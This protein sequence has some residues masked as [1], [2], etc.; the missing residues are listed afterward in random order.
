[1]ILQ[2]HVC[3]GRTLVSVS[4]GA[5][6]FFHTGFVSCTAHNNHCTAILLVDFLMPHPL[7]EVQE[8]GLPLLEETSWEMMVSSTVEENSQYTSRRLY[9]SN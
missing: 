1:M 6:L 5:Q 2:L 8:E 9:Y 4:D 7:R 3:L